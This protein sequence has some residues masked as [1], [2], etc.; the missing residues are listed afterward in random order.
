[1][2]FAVVEVIAGLGDNFV[3]EHPIPR[4]RY[5]KW[6]TAVTARSRE[7]AMLPGRWIRDGSIL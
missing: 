1:M 4:T 5:S 7:Q 6:K 3:I 2:I